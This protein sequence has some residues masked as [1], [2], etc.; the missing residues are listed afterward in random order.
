MPA[1]IRR[2][3]IPDSRLPFINAEIAQTTFQGRPHLVSSIVGYPGGRLH[4]ETDHLRFEPLIEEDGRFLRIVNGTLY[5]AVGFEVCA[6][7]L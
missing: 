6:V 3:R 4:L 5:Y 1:S 2:Y 7:E